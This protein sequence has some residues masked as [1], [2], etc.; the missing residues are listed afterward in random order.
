M[1]NSPVHSATQPSGETWEVKNLYVA[2]ASLF[3]T[4]SGVNPMVTTEAIAIH[5]A[6]NV[7]ESLKND[8][9]IATTAYEAKL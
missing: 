7:I 5:V 2:D 3:P 8:S 6:A 9:P 1:G 4:A